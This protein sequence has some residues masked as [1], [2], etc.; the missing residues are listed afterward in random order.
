MSSMLP[1]TPSPSQSFSP[2]S[3]LGVPGLS[4]YYG[5]SIL[6]RVSTTFP[7]KASWGRVFTDNSLWIAPDPHVVGP[8]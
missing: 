8:K 4:S 2:L 6:L 1:P 5:P 7:G 3:C